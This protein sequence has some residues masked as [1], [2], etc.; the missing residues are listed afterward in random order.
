MKKFAFI[1]LTVL[2]A[3]AGCTKV[4]S[5][6][7][8]SEQKIAFEVG[9]YVQQTKAYADG[10]LLKEMESIGATNQSFRSRSFLHAAGNLDNPQNYFGNGVSIRWYESAKEWAP[11]HDYYWPK[12][13]NSYLNFISWYDFAEMEG[14][15][16]GQPSIAVNYSYNTESKLGTASLTLENRTIAANDD[17]LIADV[18]WRQ[19]GNTLTYGKDGVTAGV[20]TLFRHVLSR[21]QVKMML[22]DST[23]PD[24]SSVTYEVVLQSAKIE[25]L[26]GQGT[27]TLT[28]ADP[29]SE[30]TTSWTATSN[31]YLWAPSG[32]TSD[33]VIT[34]ND[35]ADDVT[36]KTTAEPILALRS[37]MPQQLTDNVRLVVTYMVTTKSNGTVTSSEHDIPA[38]LVL[39]TVK[40]ASN[41]AINKWLP[42][43]QYT[44]NITINPISKEILLDPSVDN[45][46][47]LEF[48]ATVE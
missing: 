40:N 23:D 28:S 34:T 33:V 6:F 43:K 12:S 27:L 7:G 20:P 13:P 5:G 45:W 10:G 11:E 47:I 14:S 37:F 16:S 35:S 44:Y 17:I 9:A 26:Y 21:V 41:E 25:G 39:N 8:G 15:L 46:G 29:G 48:S 36:L 1:T 42:N 18:A 3:L 24:N 2:V 31:E 30:T 4:E 32:N 38:T 19:N 22:A